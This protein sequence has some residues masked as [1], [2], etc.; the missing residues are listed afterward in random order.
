MLSIRLSGS[1]LHVKIESHLG[2]DEYRNL[3]QLFNSLSGSF[4]WEE[5]Y[6]WVIPKDCLDELIDFMGEDKIAFFNSIEEIKGIQENVIPQFNVSNEGLDDLHLTPY[7]FQGVGISFLHD[8]KQGLLADEMGLGK[9]QPLDSK[10]LTPFGWFE[11]REI[12]VGESVIGSNGQP[13]RVTG[14]FPQGVKDIYRITFSDGSSTECCEE[15][16]WAV[17]TTTRKYRG[18]P[19]L[20]KELWEFKDDLKFENGNNKYFIPMVKPVHFESGDFAFQN[21]EEI[22]I[23]PYLLG[24]LLGNG[25]FTDNTPSVTIPDAETVSTLESLLPPTVRF[26]Q[27]TDID[28][29]IVSNVDGWSKN[30]FKQELLDLDLWGKYSYEKHVPIQYLLASIEERTY[31]LQGLLDSD[32]HV[33]PTDNNIEFSS[34]SE[35]LAKDVQFLVQSLGGTAP[36]RE[37]ETTHRLAH[38]MSISLPGNTRPFSLSRKADVYHPREKYQPTRAIV[39]VEHVGQ[40]EAQCIR[41]EAEDHLYVTDGFIVTHNTPQAIGAIHRLWKKG[42]VKKALIVCP[43]SLKYQWQN[44]IKKFTNHTGIV[45]DGTPKKRKEQLEVFQTTDEHLFC[46]INYELVRND[47]ALIQQV[48]VDAIACD[49]I[50][51]IK[52]HKTKTSQSM[53]E[54]SAPYKFGLTGTPMQNKPDELWNVM[55]WLNPTVLGNYWAFRSRYI[56]TGEKFGKRNVE[57]GYKRLGELRRRVAPYMLRRMKSDVGLELPE[58]L[59]NV[60]RVDM[61]PEQRKLQGIIQ[62]DFLNLLQDIKE[63]AEKQEGQYNALGEW[64]QPQHPKEGQMMGFFGMM[65]AVSNAPELLLMSDS[66]MARHY[67]EH[68]T[69][70][71]PKSPKLDELERICTEQLTAGNKK[72]VIFTQFARMQGLATERLQK[73]GGVEVLNGSMSPKERQSAIDSFENNDDINFFILTDA[74]NFGINLQFSNLLINIDIPWNPATFDQRAGRIHRI[75]STHDSVNVISLITLGGIDEKIEEAVYLKRQLAGQI[76]EKNSEEREQM[77]KLTAGFLESVLKTTGR[78]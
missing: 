40:K 70:A 24:Y 56:V 64:V 41:V 72:I 75:G 48:K 6:T 73:L 11:M 54:L 31:L 16:L 9:A 43:T 17:N 22:A 5:K 18:N 7:P 62:E 78:K 14:V 34:S 19:Y 61:T 57:I 50:H 44:E 65:L 12:G 52:N 28:Y 51:R 36:I 29:R 37:K 76:V 66:G 42:L 68:I 23:H 67:A 49:E 71:K 2:G 63:Y 59:F 35:Q 1:V 33:R 10:V 4:Y 45:I 26:S 3:M 58:M 69:T 55:D 74:G 60:Y 53:K 21:E 15:H 32:G 20:I 47:L 77:N 13:T 38:R 27:K 46:I 39:S 30:P 25:G 8:I